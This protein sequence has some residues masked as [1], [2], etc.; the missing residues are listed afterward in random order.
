MEEHNPSGSQSY[1][2]ITEQSWYKVFCYELVNSA[3]KITFIIH[4]VGFQKN[5]AYHSLD[6][7]VFYMHNCALKKKKNSLDSTVF[8]MHN[9]YPSLGSGRTQIVQ[10][11]SIHLTCRQII[12]KFIKSDYITPLSESHTRNCSTAFNSSHL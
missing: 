11:H 8:Y 5:T 6:N 9:A 3:S 2:V 1:L 10:R 4:N 7:V 12:Q